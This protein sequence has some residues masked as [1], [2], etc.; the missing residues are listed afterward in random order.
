VKSF[1]ALIISVLLLTLSYSS[2]V[3]AKLRTPYSPGM[4]VLRGWCS[5]IKSQ[6][7]SSSIP[8]I[9]VCAIDSET[10]S[11]VETHYVMYMAV[12]G[13]VALRNVTI[14]HAETNN[15]LDLRFNMVPGRSGSHPFRIIYLEFPTV[16]QRL[17][18]K[19]Q[20]FYISVMSIDGQ[21]TWFKPNKEEREEVRMIF[22]I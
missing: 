14:V 4:Y 13:T 12:Y 15:K 10:P 19:G 5:D 3:E 6:V 9:S 2:T 22:G 11:G 18:E 16:V 8:E 1:V 17:I 21:T 20:P 7:E